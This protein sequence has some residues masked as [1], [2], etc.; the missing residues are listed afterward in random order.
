MTK[1]VTLNCANCSK[2]YTI[3]KSVAAKGSKF[4]SKQC[5][6]DYTHIKRTCIECNKEFTAFRSEIEKRKGNGKFCSKECQ[7]NGHEYKNCL[8][9]NKEFKA[10]LSNIK[11]RCDKYCSQQCYFNRTNPIEYFFK[12]ISTENHP[13]DCWI[14]I[15]KKDKDGYGI[16]WDKQKVRAHR[17]SYELLIGSIV[18]NLFVCHTCDTPSCVNPDHLWLG[19]VLDNIRDMLS[20]NRGRYQKIKTKKLFSDVRDPVCYNKS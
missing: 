12:S 15:A 3:Y 20:K 8:T 14:W 1:F 13:N 18:N 7:S 16:M 4:C 5:N 10:Y 17:Y 6:Y 11:R 2:E 19:T 9:C